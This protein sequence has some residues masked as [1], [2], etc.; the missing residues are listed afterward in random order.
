MNAIARIEQLE[1]E[2]KQLQETIFLLKEQIDWFRRQIF[3][4]RSEKVIT[5][6][7]QPLFEGFE[8]IQQE[9]KKKQIIEKHERTKPN[10]DGNDPQ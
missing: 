8:K 5:D 6:N 4:I 7:Q 3:G 9:P 1:L 10:R 2:N